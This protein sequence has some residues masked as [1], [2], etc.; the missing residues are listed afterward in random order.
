MLRCDFLKFANR[1]GF[2]HD[3]MLFP[4]SQ[5]GIGVI[6][7]HGS[8]QNFY[9]TRFIPALAQAY[10]AAGITFLTFNLTCH[11]AV[12][13]G[14]F[15]D[16]HV[17][18]VGGAF[19]IFETCR[20]DIDAAISVI[21]S[22]CSRLILQGHSLGC[23]RVV[24]YLLQRK[25]GDLEAIL[26]SPCDSY[27]LQKEYLGGKRPEKQ[28]LFL[29]RQ[30]CRDA[31]E[32][33]PPSVYGVNQGGSWTY[34][35]PTTRRTLLSI[36]NGSPFKLFNL[37]H[38]VDYRVP[39]RTLAVIGKRDA[40]TAAGSGQMLGHLKQRFP[41]LTTSIDPES[42]HS[43]ANRETWLASELVDWVLNQSGPC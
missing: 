38:P 32:L 24:D 43:F 25:R 6:H 10:Q 21:A 19:S 13:E 18:Y 9:C 14:E 4:G 29:E 7:V 28:A 27:R 20:D 22:R 3:G 42:D 41:N 16:G 40:L 12:A 15:T 26:L 39:S 8:L 23:D 36:L 5:G 34:P 35:I 2:V 30:E 11:D 17:E 37:E 33:L 1:V 31:F